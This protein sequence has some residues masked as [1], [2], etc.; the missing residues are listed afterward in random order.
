[1]LLHNSDLISADLV[2]GIYT[3]N[4]LLLSLDID[5]ISSLIFSETL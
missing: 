5:N 4:A 3:V 2:C 1:M